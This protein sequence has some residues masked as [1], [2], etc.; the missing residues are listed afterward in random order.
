[1]T[2]LTPTQSP[3]TPL[4]N[5]TLNQQYFRA[6]KCRAHNDSPSAK[7]SADAAISGPFTRRFPL[8]KE[9]RT[10]GPPRICRNAIESLRNDV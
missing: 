6:S 1:V 2:P 8:P 4:Q 7:T 3:T 10:S 9:I 5:E